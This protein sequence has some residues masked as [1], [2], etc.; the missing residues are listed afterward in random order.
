MNLEFILQ[1]QETDIKIKRL[2]DA[3]SRGEAAEKGRQAKQVLEASRKKAADC[4]VAARSIMEQIKEAGDLSVSAKKQ[5]DEAEESVKS[6]K[7]SSKE[8]KK[9]ADELNALKN[10]I[11]ECEKKTDAKK[12]NGPKLCEDYKKES[13]SASKA[14]E[15]FK[16]AEKRFNEEKTKRAPEIDKLKARLA[17]LRPKVDPALMKIY[18]ELTAERKLPAFVDGLKMG[19]NDYTCRGCGM[20]LSKA[21]SAALKSENACRCGNC[22]RYVYIK[23]L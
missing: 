11:S 19:P 8:R 23:N 20:Q 21:D 15:I 17:E 16:Q 9:L 1:Y 2:N 4:E 22:R 5:I 12:K 10:E 7:L 6:G 14:I 3:L 18:E 13:N